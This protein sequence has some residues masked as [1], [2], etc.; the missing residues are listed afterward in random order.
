ML[1]E[2]LS[3]IYTRC[4]SPISIGQDELALILSPQ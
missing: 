4:L 3:S 2:V 1:Q